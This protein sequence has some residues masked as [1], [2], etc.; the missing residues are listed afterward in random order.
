M[1]IEKSL[2][3]STCIK[4]Y[5]FDKIAQKYMQISNIAL[6]TLFWN[7]ISKLSLYCLTFYKN[8]MGSAKDKEERI[9]KTHFYWTAQNPF[10]FI[11]WTRN[12]NEQEGGGTE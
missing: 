7:S 1:K 4:E 2:H 6:E 3:N 5:L 8:V 10:H 11:Y 12:R 9:K